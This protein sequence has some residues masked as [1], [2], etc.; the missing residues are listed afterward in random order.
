[1]CSVVLLNVTYDV[2]FILVVNR[3]LDIK[4]GIDLSNNGSF[5]CKLIDSLSSQL[6][7]DLSR[8][9]LLS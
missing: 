4:V 9:N 6:M 8:H 3:F 5:L 2:M 7:K 1:M